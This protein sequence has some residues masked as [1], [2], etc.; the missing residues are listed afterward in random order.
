MA[1]TQCARLCEIM[2]LDPDKVVGFTLETYGG[3]P[4][5]LTVSHIPP[6]EGEEVEEWEAKLAAHV[7]KY[8]L[9]P[10]EDGPDSPA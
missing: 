4:P 3:D 6:Y 2:G 8:R 5:V 10:L 1:K 9:V 7:R